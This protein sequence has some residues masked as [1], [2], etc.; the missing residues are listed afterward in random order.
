M[1]PKVALLVALLLTATA[2][3]ANGLI[4][5]E[6]LPSILS[7]IY[8]NI[9]P[10]KNG[11]DTRFGVGFRLGQHADVQFLTEIGPQIETD[12]LGE[13]ERRRSAIN[14]PTPQEALYREMA[15][16]QKLPEKQENADAVEDNWLLRWKQNVRKTR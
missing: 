16:K 13:P 9:P 8:S 6:E 14:P 1:G 2:G 3:I 5:P 12:R 10:I 15:K 4:I 7:I 11:F